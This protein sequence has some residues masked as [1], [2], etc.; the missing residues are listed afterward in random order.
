MPSDIPATFPLQLN[1]SSLAVVAPGLTAKYPTAVP[2]RVLLPANTVECSAFVRRFAATSLVD[3][4]GSVFVDC[5]LLPVLSH[6]V[7]G[8]RWVVQ[9][10]LFAQADPLSKPDVKITA[11][12]N[13]AVVQMPSLLSFRPI[14]AAGQPAVDGFT[15]SCPLQ[16]VATISITGE[17]PPR[18]LLLPHAPRKNLCC[19]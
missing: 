6:C 9:V 15:L 3:V 1:T 17:S 14:P 5:V 8:S 11:A 2:V 12:D 19:G 7:N 10:E 13:G 16:G 18:V 4:L